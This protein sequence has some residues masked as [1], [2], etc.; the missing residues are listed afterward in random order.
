[1]GFTNSMASL[2]LAG[3][4]A[5]STKKWMRLANYFNMEWRDMKFIEPKFKPKGE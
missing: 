1:M 2:V 3:T 4:L 5:I